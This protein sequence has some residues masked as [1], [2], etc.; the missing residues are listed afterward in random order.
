M[1]REKSEQELE[2]QHSRVV[3]KYTRDFE[4]LKD[5]FEATEEL[6]RKTTRKAARAGRE[7]LS[8][9]FLGPYTGRVQPDQNLINFLTGKGTATGQGMTS[10]DY[11]PDPTGYEERYWEDED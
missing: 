2:Q 5:R 10:R 7:K 1:A 11:E 9:E 6:I 4:R 8:R 3:D